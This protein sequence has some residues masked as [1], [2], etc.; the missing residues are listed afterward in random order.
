MPV[1]EAHCPPELSYGFPN[2]R[3]AEVLHGNPAQ[4]VQRRPA[5]CSSSRQVV[6]LA[7]IDE[8]ELSNHVPFLDAVLV[9]QEFDTD[10]VSLW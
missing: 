2:P 5:I 10:H 7:I 8:T 3:G 9:L 1:I 4:T 6:T